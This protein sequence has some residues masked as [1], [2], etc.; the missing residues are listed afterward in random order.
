MT[1]K[2]EPHVPSE[3]AVKAAKI[4]SKI[5]NGLHH[6]PVIKDFGEYAASRIH[7]ASTYDLDELT[8]LVVAAHDECVRIEIQPLNMQG[9]LILFHQRKR[10]GRICVSH[11]ELKQAVETIREKFRAG[12]KGWEDDLKYVSS[13]IIRGELR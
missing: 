4:L 10:M 12:E 1:K 7:G 13:H 11:P 9:L 5:Y 2:K 6:C 3:V 8:Q